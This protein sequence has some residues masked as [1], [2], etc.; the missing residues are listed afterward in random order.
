MNA[1]RTL[2]TFL[3][4]G[5]YALCIL[6][7]RRDPGGRDDIPEPI[8][9]LVQVGREESATKALSTV[10]T[11]LLEGAVGDLQVFVFDPGGVIDGYARS[12]SRAAVVATYT[13]AHDVWAV[14][15]APD[16]SAVT[17]KAALLA[18]VADLDDEGVGSLVHVGGTEVNLS[19]LSEVNLHVD[20]LSSRA[21]VR[22]VTNKLSPVAVNSQTFV[23]TDL[24]MTNVARTVNLG[25]TGLPG[26]WYNRMGLQ[27]EKDVLLHDALTSGT[28]ALDAS[29]ADEH[30]F[31]MMPNLTE[32][33]SHSD[34]WSPRHT[35]IV[36]RA[37]IGGEE[38]FYPIPLPKQAHGVSYEAAEV[39]VSRIGVKDEETLLP[40]TAIEYDIS[41]DG[42][43]PQSGN[44][45]IAFQSCDCDVVFSEPGVNPFDLLG[46]D[47]DLSA[48]RNAVIFSD[49][50]ISPWE[51][52]TVIADGA[53][54]REGLSY[55]IFTGGG[56]NAFDLYGSL[57]E[58]AGGSVIGFICGTSLSAFEDVG[59]F[60]SAGN[61]TVSTFVFGDGTVL[62]PEEIARII[63]MASPAGVNL[64]FASGSVSGAEQI[65]RILELLC[66]DGDVNIVV[67]SS[68]AS[69]DDIVSVIRMK[70]MSVRVSVTVVDWEDDLKSDELPADD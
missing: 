42:F 4:T 66:C 30:R 65:G 63:N 12:G 59:G 70:D 55:W 53:V 46:R 14:T 36:L 10:S 43:V 27:G 35:R 38:E 51:A 18:T 24:Y 2:G 7:C 23:P 49:G 29:L 60:L 34:T 44:L 41:L 54:N 28:L 56:L 13:G 68:V 64:V 11:D 17:T 58:L 20:H 26:S 32:A 52:Q 39:V 1:K 47:T 40:F 9:V 15:N 37:T 8:S 62:S 31:Y 61:A 5:L 19:K 69:F 22:K 6:S 3:V 57:L 25:A 33:D 45:D 21:V 16:L 50:S 48:G 67:S